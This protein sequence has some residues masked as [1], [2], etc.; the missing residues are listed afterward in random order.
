MLAADRAHVWHPYASATAPLPVLPVAS[1]KGV[2]IQLTDGRELV[3]AM[4]S[5]WATIHGYRVPELDAAVRSQLDA[6]SHVMF[7]GLTHEPAVRLAERLVEIT[8]EGLDRVFFTDS[9]SVAVEVALKMAT[10]YWSAKGEHARSRML[11]VR[12]GYHGDT[13]GAM[14]VCDPQTGM[15]R[16]FPGLSQQLFAERPAATFGATLEPHHTAEL[17]RL[18]DEHSLELAAIILEPIVQGAGGMYFYA[19]GYLARVRDLCNQHGVLLIT[20]EIATGFGRTGTLFAGEHAGITP[21]IM[22][23]GKAMTGGYVSMGA[24]LC[25]D[26][27]AATISGG[28]AGAFMHG[29]TFMANPLAAAVSLASID[30]LLSTDWAA[31]VA[32]ISSRLATGLEPARSLPGVADVRVLGAIGVIELTDPVDLA[33]ITPLFVERGVWVRPFGRLVYT[34]PPY[35]TEDE[36]VDLITSAMVEVV[37]QV[38]T[39]VQRNTPS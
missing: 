9:G 37:T 26:D 38:V 16:L 4:S 24:T 15:H 5:W 33:Q 6:M 7:G 30:L 17:E 21:D 22:C 34:M 27:I 28:P 29:P 25:T 8:P 32:R 19:P 2:R 10:Q 18:L 36:D 20:D 35:V 1:A 39:E 23:V 13:I 31:T 14:S 3:D 12:G 11:T